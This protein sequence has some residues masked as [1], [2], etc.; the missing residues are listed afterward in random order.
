[1]TFQ[2]FAGRKSFPLQRC[3]VSG[4]IPRRTGSLV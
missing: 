3:F 1:V 4:I 2:G